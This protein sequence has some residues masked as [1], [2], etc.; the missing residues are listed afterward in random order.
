[1]SG[2]SD[3]G[4][5]LKLCRVFRNPEESRCVW[6]IHTGTNRGQ[7]EDKEQAKYQYLETNFG[8]VF[9]ERVVTLAMYLRKELYLKPNGKI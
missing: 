7:A 2:L 9:K 8:N 3:T 6:E 4:R 1:M 5:D